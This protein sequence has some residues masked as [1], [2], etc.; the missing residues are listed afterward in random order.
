MYARMYVRMR[1]DRN[2]CVHMHYIYDGLT[3]VY[4]YIYS[5]SI[6]TQ[7]DTYTCGNLELF[8]PNPLSVFQPCAV[9]LSLSLEVPK[10][11]YGK[12]Q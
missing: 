11:S 1:T 10:N 5:A 9:H 4:L 2:I 8:L 12:V 3:Y 6:H 7:S